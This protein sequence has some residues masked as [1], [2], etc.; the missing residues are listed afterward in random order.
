MK[1]DCFRFDFPVLD[2]DF[3]A[4]QHNG[5]AFTNSDQ[6]SVPIRDVLVGDT[7]GYVEH[8]NRAL[9]LDIIPVSQA[10]E[11]LLP[12]RVP[13]VESDGPPVRVEHQRVHFNTESR[14]V[15]F[16][17]LSSQMSFYECGFAST[18][19]ADQHALECGHI[20]SHFC[21]LLMLLLV[22]I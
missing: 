15:S 3:V 16:L 2:I 8:D 13:H 20:I 17:E 12:C 9:T 6:I 7:R 22:F 21:V 4:A 11:L 19:V 1:N 5:D 14:N 10:S 18:A